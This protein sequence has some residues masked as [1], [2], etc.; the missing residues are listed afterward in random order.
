MVERIKKLIIELHGSSSLV[1]SL[2]IE[3]EFPYLFKKDNLS[4]LD[5]FIDTYKQFGI[6][7]KTCEEDCN[8]KIYLSGNHQDSTDSE[9][10]DGHFD[11]CSDIEFTK[12]GKFIRQ[13][14][15]E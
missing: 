7:V 11:F 2:E 13:G 8:I 10:F 15:W 4:D 6:D 1:R 9:K 12:E 3:K 5:K 14:F